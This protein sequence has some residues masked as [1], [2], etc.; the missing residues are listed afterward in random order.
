ME[1]SHPKDLAVESPDGSSAGVAESRCILNQRFETG[2]EIKRRPAD[3]FEDFAG[4]GLLIQRL[5]QTLLEVTAP[6]AV[7]LERLAGGSGLDRSFHGLWTPTHRPLLACHS[8]AT[9]D[10]LGEGDGISKWP[11]GRFTRPE[12]RP[13]R[14]SRDHCAELALGRAGNQGEES[15]V[16]ASR[17][18]GRMTSAAA[19]AS[20]RYC[21][22][23][24][25]G[26]SWEKISSRLPSGS[27]K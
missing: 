12:S 4:R 23:R 9:D 6:G 24:A 2:L 26:N 3:D 17:S 25:L 5:R 20:C 13:L 19:R 8:A 14:P 1:G 21:L 11:A 7:V 18:S 22:A 27:K 16:A 10:R 15:Y